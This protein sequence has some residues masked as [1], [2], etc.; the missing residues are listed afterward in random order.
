M[1]GKDGAS[2]KQERLFMSLAEELKLPLQQIARRAELGLL[3]GEDK[4]DFE[5]I[6]V[7]AD[8]TLQ[9]LDSYLLS[10]R[11]AAEPDERFAVEPVC[12]SA[13]LHEARQQLTKTAKQYGVGL[14]L[15]IQG[16]YEPVM[17]HRYALKAALVSLG[18]TL[19]EALPAMGSEQLL[20]HLA[21]HRTKN[22]IVAGMYCEAE[23]LTPQVLRCAK[24]LGGS[25]RQSIVSLSPASGAGVFIA[26]AIL[27]AMSS[28]LRVGRYR[29]LP[30]FAVTLLPSK[31]L[32][33]V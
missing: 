2:D 4:R 30:G 23:E 9:L 6:Q 21:A 16:N 25:A 29:K 22:G 10:L 14:E 7:S 31:Q 12:V 18:Y 3:M 11:L 28:R 24:E 1:L 20:L 19:I 8:N 13:V 33:L 15:I 26:D 17:A 27:A 5:Y 32:E